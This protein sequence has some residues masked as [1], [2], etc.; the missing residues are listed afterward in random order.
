MQLSIEKYI[1]LPQRT[2]KLPTRAVVFFDLTNQ[3]NSR[4]SG[5][6]VPSIFFYSGVPLFFFWGESGECEHQKTDRRRTKRG[7]VFDTMRINPPHRRDF[8][9]DLQ[10]CWLI[11]RKI[12]DRQCTYYLIVRA[13]T[14]TDCCFF[15]QLPPFGPNNTVNCHFFFV[16]PPSTCQFESFK[17][18]EWH[19]EGGECL[20][21]CPSWLECAQGVTVMLP[22]VHSSHKG[23]SS[24]AWCA[25]LSAYR[26]TS[27]TAAAVSSD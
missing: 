16:E 26:R 13:L 23:A 20:W 21:T 24:V 12:G 8:T 5:P 3:F 6:F 1:G 11:N 4:G 2:N 22:R 15:L 19:V 9:I 17:D 27:T 7:R 10:K 18:A 14:V 25:C